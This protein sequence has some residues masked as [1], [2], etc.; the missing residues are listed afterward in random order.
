MKLVVVKNNF[1]ILLVPN[2]RDL[3]RTIRWVIESFARKP[4]FIFELQ[5]FE[6][7]HLPP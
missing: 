5:N 1:P 2:D 6:N 3:R 4:F 7:Y